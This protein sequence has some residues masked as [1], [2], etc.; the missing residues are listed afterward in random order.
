LHFRKPTENS[1]I[2][3]QYW[4]PVS[5][6]L[7]ILRLGANTKWKASKTIDTEQKRNNMNIYRYLK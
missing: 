7:E 2:T 6:Y 5:C 1:N 4:L 3:V